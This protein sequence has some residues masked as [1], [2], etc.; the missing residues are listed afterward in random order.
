MLSEFW[1]WLVI[2][3]ALTGALCWISAILLVIFFWMCRRP[4][5][6]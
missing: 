3:M 6:E 2:L 5:Q 4:P 1:N